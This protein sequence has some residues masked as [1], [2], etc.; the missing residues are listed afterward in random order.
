MQPGCTHA[1]S[2]R[3]LNAAASTHEKFKQT[4]HGMFLGNIPRRRWFGD[5]SSQ[6]R[7]KRLQHDE[8][9]YA[10][11]ANTFARN[12]LTYKAADYTTL[13]CAWVACCLRP[14]YLH[15]CSYRGRECCTHR[16]HVNNIAA[17]GASFGLIPPHLAPPSE[18]NC[19]RQY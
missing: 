6:S 4:R 9:A 12:C 5:Q 17:T 7:F 15:S 2:P 16:T 14:L 8:H 1:E 11:R 3:P 10:Y 19:K 13:T 18:L